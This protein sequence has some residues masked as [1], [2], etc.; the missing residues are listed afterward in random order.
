MFTQ[1]PD[2]LD[3]L[4]R[5]HAA[6]VFRY[7][8]SLVGDDEV[9]R[10]LVQDTFLRLGRY[11][12]R[13]DG[14]EAIGAGLVFAT[15]R[16]CGLDHL[17]RRQVRQRHETSLDPDAR[18]QLPDPTAARAD[19]AL[20]HAQIRRDL[21]AALLD[22]PEDQRTVFHLSEVEGLTYDAIAG[23]LGISP[24]T[25]ASRK[26]HAVRKLRDQLRRLGHDA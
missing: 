7:L 4:A 5:D 15:A 14:R 13:Q 23:V 1:T 17:R 6:G 8:R 26:H 24:G 12:A 2:T 25:V 11:A 20:E 10:D 22:L 3:T 19:Q 16:N 21:T 9:A 18:H